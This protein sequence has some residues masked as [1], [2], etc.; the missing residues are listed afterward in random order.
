MYIQYYTIHIIIILGNIY[1]C[2]GPL[3]GPFLPPVSC[4]SLVLCL[5]NGCTSEMIKNCIQY[6]SIDSLVMNFQQFQIT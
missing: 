2:F 6:I 1:C 4:L 3:F 5:N